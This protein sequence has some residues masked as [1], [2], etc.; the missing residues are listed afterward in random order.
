M[1]HR[2]SRTGVA[3]AGLECTRHSG[4][5]GTP[6]AGTKAGR[7]ELADGGTQMF[8][9]KRGP[10]DRNR[11]SGAPKGERPDRKGRKAPRKRLQA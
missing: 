5:S 2:E 7:E 11:H 1:R 9:E 4:G 6:P 8:H 10:E 3:P